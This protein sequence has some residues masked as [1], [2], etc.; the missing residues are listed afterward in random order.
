MTPSVS[1]AGRS[2]I[3]FSFS[4]TLSSIN[5]KVQQVAKSTFTVIEGETKMELHFTATSLED[6]P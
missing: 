2:P 4:A 1:E 6:V 3:S 5:T